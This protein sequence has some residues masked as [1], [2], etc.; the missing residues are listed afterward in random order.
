MKI[1]TLKLRNQSEWQ[2]LLDLL[3]RL[4][5]NFEWREEENAS[6]KNIP[7]H[8]DAIAELFGC[9]PSD[10]SSDELIESIMDARISQTREVT[11]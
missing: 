10:K 9:W 1:I 8:Q 3:R 5:I 4:N 6:K 2:F 11:L 7:P